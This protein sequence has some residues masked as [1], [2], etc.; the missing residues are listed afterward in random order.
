MV[1]ISLILIAGSV[2]ASVRR[3]GV[4]ER[5]GERS[6]VESFVRLRPAGADNVRSGECGKRPKTARPGRLHR[7]AAGSTTTIRSMN[8]P[9]ERYLPGDEALRNYSRNLHHSSHMPNVCNGTRS[10]MER[11]RRADLGIISE[12]VFLARKMAQQSDVE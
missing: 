3:S 11:G 4:L 1:N 10:F 8:L 5:Q 7:G 6:T 2:L 9:E 12:G